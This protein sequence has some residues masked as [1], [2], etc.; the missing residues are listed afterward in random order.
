V[1]AARPGTP[2]E[3]LD[4]LIVGAGLSGI[5]AAYHVQT[6]CPWA[7]Y[8]VFEARD[9]IGG[10]WDLFRYPG[11]RSDSD[12]FTL[13]YS[14]RPWAEEQS[15]ADG[16][17]ILSYVRET[18]A[19]F[20]IDRRIRFGHRIVSAAWSS[21]DARWLITAERLD[22]D[23][24]VVDTVTLTC[25]FLFSCSGYYRYDRGYQPDFAGMDDF[26]GTLVH[27]QFWPEDL[28][29]TGRRV[30]VIG[31]GATAVTL[32]PALASTAE[33]VTMLQRSPTYVAS[34]PARNPLTR[35]VRKV[36][37]RRWAP[38]TLRWMNALTTQAFFRVSKLRPQL[39]KRALRKGLERELPPGYDIDTHF[40]PTYDPWDQRLCVVPD[41]DL[42]RAIRDGR[43]SVVTD[44]IDTFVPEGI[45]LQS[46]EV[47]PADVVVSATGLELLFIGGIEMSVDGEVVEPGERLAYKGMML[48][49]V[50]NFAMAVGYTN[51][52]WTLKAELTCGHVCRVLERM[53]RSGATRCV[54]RNTDPS[55]T[56]SPLL[57]LTA[58]Y[59][60]RSK[61][62]FPQQGSTA[63]WQMHQSYL[64]DHRIMKRGPVDDPALEFSR[65]TS[66]HGVLGERVTAG[67]TS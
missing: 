60:Q 58:G 2:T 17:S 48:E 66:R 19:E 62:R 35:V 63:P 47:L 39:V 55:V 40:T 9:S 21:D 22:A 12:M 30:V 51:A 3:H 24:T 59:I 26:A 61:D 4:V 8:A 15:I 56:T 42:F 5:A 36:V 52:S 41:G 43:A 13:G 53:H 54:P 32:I 29:V 20:G 23:G 44:H 33:H 57:G 64:K 18:A 16:A 6:S 25:G 10:T 31:S 67:A 7:S 28:D 1:S 38:T 34:L 45:R 46:G 14:F 50:P 49:G 27:P 37:P 11:I 65:P